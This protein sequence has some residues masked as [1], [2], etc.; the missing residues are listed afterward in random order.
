MGKMLHA[1]LNVCIDVPD[2]KAFLKQ[3]HLEKDGTTALLHILVA[4]KTEYF[5]LKGVALVL[6]Q[7]VSQTRVGKMDPAKIF[8]NIKEYWDGYNHMRPK[9]PLD[10][11]IVATFAVTV[12]CDN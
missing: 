6:K 1:V 3:C 5:G 4:L 7:L 10:T 8:E 11:S 9:E 12:L 2:L